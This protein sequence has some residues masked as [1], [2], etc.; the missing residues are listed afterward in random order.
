MEDHLSKVGKEIAKLRRE[1]TGERRSFE[2]IR[3]RA[4]ETCCAAIRVRGAR[5][6]G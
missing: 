3:D 6:S 1:L 4:V 5:Q 2:A